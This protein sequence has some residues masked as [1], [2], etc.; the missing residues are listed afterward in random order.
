[1]IL[2]DVNPL[3]YAFRRDDPKHAISRAW[4]EG[5][6]VALSREGRSVDLGTR[7]A[8]PQIV[9]FSS[10]EMTP[11]A[12]TFAL[13]DATPYR[14]TGSDDGTTRRDRVEARR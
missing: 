6:R 7:D 9:C 3:I 4:L 11:F 13:G 5:V 2:P 14:I 10:G 8:P 12:L 1:M